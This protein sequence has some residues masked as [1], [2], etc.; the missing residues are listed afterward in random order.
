MENLACAADR[1]LGSIGGPVAKEAGPKS[2]QPL[3]SPV[4][5]PVGKRR[6]GEGRSKR[7]ISLPPSQ[8]TLNMITHV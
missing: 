1:A 6:R 7:D 4:G 5:R 3:S 2:R 8:H